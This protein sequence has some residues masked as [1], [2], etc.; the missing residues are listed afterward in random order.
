MFNILFI[1]CLPFFIILLSNN[2]LFGI[3]D[4]VEL[5]A[6]YHEKYI[7]KEKKFLKYIEE[8]QC[9][10][11]YLDFGTN[12]GVQIRKVYE[13]KY[14]PD[15]KVMPLFKEWFGDEQ[16]HFNVCSA[17]FEPNESHIKRLEELES[18]YQKVVFV[19]ITIMSINLNYYI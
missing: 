10:K 16:D 3:C 7:Q 13:P 9:H 11:I 6:K 1:L 8:G 18:S 12:I 14:Y 2:I 15:A 5:L 4:D 19:R 17:G